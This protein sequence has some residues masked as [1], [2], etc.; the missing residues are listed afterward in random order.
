MRCGLCTSIGCAQADLLSPQP[1]NKLRV[2]NILPPLRAL[3][4][5]PIRNSFCYSLPVLSVVRQDRPL[6]LL[7]LRSKGNTQARHKMRHEATFLFSRP[8]F[9]ASQNVVRARTGAHSRHRRPR[10]IWDAL[11]HDGAGMKPIERLVNRRNSALKLGAR[12][13]DRQRGGNVVRVQ[14]RHRSLSF[15]S[16]LP[17]QS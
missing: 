10:R 17:D 2:Q 8:S 13:R 3:R 16:R 6:Q 11:S 5:R 9:S 7:V 15:T 14:Q 4:R 1:F 12:V